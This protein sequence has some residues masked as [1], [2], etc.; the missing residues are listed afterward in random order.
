MYPVRELHLSHDGV[1]TDRGCFFAR[2]YAMRWLST[3]TIVDLLIQ[4][5]RLEV[6]RENGR[7]SLP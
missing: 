4:S 6:G 2:N 5:K 3:Y 1:C 7:A